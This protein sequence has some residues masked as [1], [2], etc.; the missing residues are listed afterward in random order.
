MTEQAPPDYYFQNIIF[1]PKYYD[2]E[3]NNNIT[4][5]EADNKYIKYN[6][7]NLQLTKTVSGLT[8][9]I[10]DLRLTSIGRLNNLFNLPTNTST[11]TPY[12]RLVLIDNTTRSTTWFPSSGNVGYNSTTS[13]LT[14][15]ND[16]G[17]IPDITDLV[18]SGSIGSSTAEKFVLPSNSS[19]ATVNSV[20]A[21]SNTSTKATT[22]ISLPT[23]ISDY[24][25]YNTSTNKISKI[26]SIGTTIINDLVLSNKIGSLKNQMFKLPTNISSSFIGATIRI[27]DNTT[28]PITTEWE[29]TPQAFNPYV[30]YNSTSK[31]L[32]DNGALG[33]S[34]ITDLVVSSSIGSSIAQKFVLPSNSSLSTVGQVLSILNSTSKTTQWITIPTQISDYVRFNPTTN[35]LSRVLNGSAST[36]TLLTVS[37]LGSNTSQRFALPTNSSTAPADYVLSINVAAINNGGAPSTIWKTIPTQISSYVNY[38]NANSNLISNVSGIPSTI[39]S[40]SISGLLTTGNINSGAINANANLIET[41]GNLQSRGLIIKNTS[42]VNVCSI[43]NQGNINITGAYTGSN[44]IYTSYGDIQTSNGN[45]YTNNGNLQSRG[46]I[47]KNTSDINVATISNTGAY[48]GSSYIYTLS[49]NIE[50]ANGNIQ[51][52]NGNIYTNNGNLQ[53]RGLIIKNA[54]DVTVGAFNE[55]GGLS[56]TAFQNNG[57]TLNC[58]NITSGTINTQNNT[59]NAGTSSISGGSILSST[60]NSGA[61]GSDL[62]IGTNQVAGN[63]SI[64]NNA[65]RT[66][67]VNICTLASNNSINICNASSTQQLNINRPIRMPGNLPFTNGLEI[68]Y[69]LNTGVFFSSTNIPN[70]APVPNVRSDTPIPSGNLVN[71]AVYLMTYTILIVPQ[72]TLDLSKF[73]YGIFSGSTFMSGFNQNHSMITTTNIPMRFNTSETYSYSGSGHFVYSSGVTY[74]LSFIMAFLSTAPTV[75]TNVELIRIR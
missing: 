54:S 65:S 24:V 34:I 1:N 48:T 21:L 36:I 16:S 41:T 74:N 4:K 17:A 12:S 57:N 33:S 59:I 64:G 53:S 37:T 55:Y 10:N 26:D 43:S 75:Q 47:I 6:S 3:I 58:G 67:S 49:G 9:T 30:S 39:T 14:T 7:S 44:Y 5:Y 40:I 45:I 60:F 22:W 62:D 56:C 2:N 25:Q 72:A 46:L 20:L 51:T 70:N 66:G 71:G 69:A 27:L 63:L 32:E 13:I 23:A 38:N 11:A 52:Q 68:G 73:Q 29:T 31:Q 8:T 61:P 15:E 18:M 35:D 19:S 28:D 50:T 42:N